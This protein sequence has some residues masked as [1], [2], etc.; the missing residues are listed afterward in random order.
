MH[1][2]LQLAEKGARVNFL[3]RDVRTFGRGAEG[4]YRE[5]AQRGVR[6]V[7]FNEEPT[8]DGTDVTVRDVFSDTLLALPTDLLVLSVAM[9]PHADSVRSLS[10]ALKLSTGSEGYFAEKHVKLGPVETAIEGVFL[11][12]CA[13]GPRRIEESVASASGAA[14]KASALLSRD[15]VLVDPVVAE[16]AE[17]RCRWCGRC[18]EVCEFHAVELIARPVG[19]V[20]RVNP[21]LCK[22]CG[23]CVVDCPTGAMSMKGF[24]TPQVEAQVEALLQEAFE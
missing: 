13:A 8:F 1:Q 23:V 7:R 15:T 22:G 6:F 17:P 4:L 12:G 18:A 11:A 20:A 21:A 16:V 14:A 3:Y 5:A 19:L 9:R 2:A 10:N 24:S